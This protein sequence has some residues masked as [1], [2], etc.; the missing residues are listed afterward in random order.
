[1]FDCIRKLFIWLGFKVYDF[2]KDSEAQTLLTNEGRKIMEE[3]QRTF[4][5]DLCSKETEKQILATR[6]HSNTNTSIAVSLM[7]NY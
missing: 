1:M 2:T 3:T 7:S 6:S 4:L 5:D